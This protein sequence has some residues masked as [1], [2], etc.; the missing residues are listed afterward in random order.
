MNI[1]RSE[2]QVKTQASILEACD[3]LKARVDEITSDLDEE[4]VSEIWIT[5]RFTPDGDPNLSIE[6]SYTPVK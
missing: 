1:T 4:R 3:I 6:K 5:M 2:F